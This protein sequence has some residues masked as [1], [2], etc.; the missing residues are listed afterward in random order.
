MRLSKQFPLDSFL[1]SLLIHLLILFLL[2]FVNLRQSV[3]I[4]ELVIDWITELT[5][6][7]FEENFAPAGSNVSNIRSAREIT[8]PRQTE[9]V[10]ESPISEDITPDHRVARSIEPPVTRPN[11]NQNTSPSPG[12]SSSYL[13]GVMSSISGSQSG[14]SGF[15]LEDDDGTITVLKSV[16]PAPKISDYGKVTLMFKIRP[17]G[18]VNAESVVPVIIDDPIYTN[19]SIKALKQWLFSV[20]NYNSNKAY[21]ISF[22]FKPE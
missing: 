7:V 19:E 18:S 8:D 5:P 22:I 21:R 15:Q 1:I 17:D 13:S 4:K 6:P 2:S 20:R 16:L 11:A 3:T 12:V 14:N 10:R 9:Q